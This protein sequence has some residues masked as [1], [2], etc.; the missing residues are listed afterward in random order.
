LLLVLAC[1]CGPKTKPAPIVVESPAPESAGPNEIELYEPKAT[2]VE[3]MLVQFE[4]KY[5]FT[6]GRPNRVYSCE[7]FFP[8]TLNHGVKSMDS[9]QL[10]TEGV[11]KDGVNLRETPV[12]EFEIHISEAVTPQDGF[13][14]ISNV[15]RGEVK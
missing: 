13:K 1:G 15:V 4:V 6:K 3:P 2:L 5:R 7:I 14:K 9:W 10:Q 11:I 8:G 12:K